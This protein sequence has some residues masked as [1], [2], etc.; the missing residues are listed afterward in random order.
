M[1]ILVIIF[2]LAFVGALSACDPKASPVRTSSEDGN[3][4]RIHADQEV[5]LTSQAFGCEMLSRF[6]KAVEHYS[7]QEL[8]AWAQIT[9]DKP[10]CFNSA[11]LP[12]GMYWT[13]LQVRGNLM[14]VKQTTLSQYE[15]DRDLGTHS[16][17]TAVAWAKPYVAPPRAS[18]PAPVASAPAARR[19]QRHS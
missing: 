4:E 3:P 5:T 16:F 12:N 10:Y 13:V 15:L 17:W 11:T 1:N 8:T 6:S 18:A 9:G 19:R 14:E 2:S 7:R